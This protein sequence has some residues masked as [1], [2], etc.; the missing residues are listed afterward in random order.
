MEDKHIDMGLADYYDHITFNLNNMQI[1]ELVLTDFKENKEYNNKENNVFFQIYKSSVNIYD[2]T[3]VTVC[4]GQFNI[5]DKGKNILPFSL[6][7]E[8]EDGGINY[9]MLIYKKPDEVNGT[10]FYKLEGIGV[11]ES[12][13]TSEEE[14]MPSRAD[15]LAKIDKLTGALESYQKKLKIMKKN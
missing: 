13:S 12:S 8:L 7:S 2:S 1:N 14:N 10:L 15:L 3:A 4:S 5:E 9:S 11:D 6:K